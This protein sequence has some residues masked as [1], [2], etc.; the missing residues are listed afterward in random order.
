M[1][2]TPARTASTSG[3]AGALW[4]REA[5]QGSPAGAQRCAGRRRLWACDPEQFGAF[6]KVGPQR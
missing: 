4:P 1:L 2:L 5:G 3:P 6:E